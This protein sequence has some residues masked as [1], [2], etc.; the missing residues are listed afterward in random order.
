L[1][2]T[3]YEGKQVYIGLDLHREFSVR[4]CIS[5]GVVVKRCRMPG[6]DRILVE[7]GKND[8]LDSVYRSVPGIAPRYSASPF[9]GAWRYLHNRA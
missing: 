4:R 5:D 2:T 9:I 7:E 8:P 6:I 1:K 3:S